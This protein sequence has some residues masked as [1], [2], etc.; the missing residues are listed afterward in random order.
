VE[1]SLFEDLDHEMLY[2]PALDGISNDPECA[3]LGIA[4]LDV[5]A[6]F[7]PF[8]DRT[9]NPYAAD[10]DTGPVALSGPF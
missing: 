2:D 5:A 6:W 1:D 3:S 9:V 10:D 4:D 8:F 7:V